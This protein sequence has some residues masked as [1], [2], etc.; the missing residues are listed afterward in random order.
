MRADARRRGSREAYSCGVVVEVV[1]A[2][3]LKCSKNFFQIVTTRQD[4]AVY[5]SSAHAACV[6]LGVRW[7]DMARHGANNESL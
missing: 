5:I 6:T 2:K 3:I 4:E 7:H 1:M